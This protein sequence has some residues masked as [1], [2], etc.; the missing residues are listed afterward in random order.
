MCA[1]VCACLSVFFCCLPFF[2]ASF[3]L[4]FP[5]PCFLHSCFFPPF[6]VLSVFESFSPFCFLYLLVDNFI[7]TQLF[8]YFRRILVYN[9]RFY[10]CVCVCYTYLISMASHQ[11][12]FPK[13]SNH[14]HHAGR[15]CSPLPAF[16]GIS[17]YFATQHLARLTQ[18]LRVPSTEFWRTRLS[19]TLPPY[20]FSA[21]I[22]VTLA[23]PHKPTAPDGSNVNVVSDSRMPHTTSSPTST[24]A[25]V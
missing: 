7:F 25:L 22:Q 15:T 5:F 16:E 23:H 8:A 10:I 9:L 2:L 11:F 3:L 18:A 21:T 19:A 14:D 17:R 13:A 1:Y 4:F 20:V 24:I 6:F 12:G